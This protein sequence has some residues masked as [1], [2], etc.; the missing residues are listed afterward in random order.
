MAKRIDNFADYALK[1]DKKVFSDMDAIINDAAAYQRYTYF[2]AFKRQ[3]NIQEGKSVND[4]VE[5]SYVDTAEWV[6]AGHIFG[7]IQ[8]E[9]G[10]VEHSVGWADLWQ[11]IAWIEDETEDEGDR[12]VM[13]K[14]IYK[15]K[16]LRKAQNTYDKLEASL[17]AAPNDRMEIP[18]GSTATATDVPRLP[19]SIPSVITS[20]NAATPVYS[21]FSAGTVAQINAT[22]YAA[23]RNQHVDIT[24]WEDEI[25]DALFDMYY[26]SMWETAGGPHDSLMTGTPKD[27]CVVYADL[28]SIKRTRKV[29]LNRND[30]LS[31]LGAR[32][33]RVEYGNYVITWAPVLG[34]P[35]I[36]DTAQVMYGV[37]WD[38]LVPMVRKSRFL[39]L[40]KSRA[41]GAEFEFPNQPTARALYERT[42]VQLFPRSRKRLWKIGVAA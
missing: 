3:K 38:F 10:S 2:E 13:W 39:K 18:I 28:K 37:H 42:Q 40:I 11:R 23:W 8:V 9:D 1:M 31:K 20:T 26:L 19:L 16:R 6:A 24:N 41:T 14:S 4:Y 21:S 5:L 12:E 36:A 33:T 34:G 30:S 27:G 32:D 35:S 29:L 7:E 17:W 22:T 15:G 25:E